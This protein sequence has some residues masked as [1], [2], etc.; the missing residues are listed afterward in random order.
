MTLSGS[1]LLNRNVTVH[2]RRTSMRLEP[3][4]WDALDEICR[5]EHFSV[6]EICSL[7]AERHNGNNLTAATRVFILSYFRAAATDDGHKKAGH[8]RNA[9]NASPV[10]VN[11]PASSGMRR[12]V[13]SARANE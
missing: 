8:G 9:F 6:H 11:H 2:G 5:R 7:I 13:S 10:F 3:D 1:Y 4:M 12:N